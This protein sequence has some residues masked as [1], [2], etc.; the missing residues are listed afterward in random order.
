MKTYFIL[1]FCTIANFC[2]AQYPVVTA[3]NILAEQTANIYNGTFN[4]SLGISSIVLGNVIKTETFS[5]TPFSD[6]PC[7]GIFPN[8][9]FYYKAHTNST[10]LDN[11]NHYY[12]SANSILKLNSSN[13]Q[14][15]SY[16]APWATFPME[17]TPLVLGQDIPSDKYNEFLPTLTTPL[18]T[19]TNVIVKRYDQVYGT[20]TS[21]YFVR[22]Y[23]TANPY[24]Q[25][26]KIYS[27][28]IA[29][30]NSEYWLWDYPSNLGNQNQENRNTFT[31]YPNPS[32]NFITIDFQNDFQDK[33][34]YKIFDIIGRIVKEG[35]I[36]N[37][38]TINIEE[39]NSGNYIIEVVNENQQKL[40]NK[41]I[42]L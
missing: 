3:S 30:P 39:L 42:K 24:R 16:E 26:M 29:Y 10:N 15:N 14:C 19:Y 21:R 38:E 1:L 7:N 37:S 36:K 20:M 27:A 40:I 34:K 41:F 25:I 17:Y 35:E 5:S 23:F 31:I 2:F 32:N 18:G 6:F 13:N 22:T 33:T 8:A 9:N 12:F 11:F 4:S 28:Y